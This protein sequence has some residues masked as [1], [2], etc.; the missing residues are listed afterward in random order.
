MVTITEVPI[1]T[2]ISTSSGS[3]RQIQPMEQDQAVV[4]GQEAP[5]AQ[6]LH[7]LALQISFTYYVYEQKKL[8]SYLLSV[9]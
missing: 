2:P 7:M 6:V 8:K 4:E 3:D 1:D 9:N 5:P